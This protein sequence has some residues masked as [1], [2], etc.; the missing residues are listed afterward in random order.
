MAVEAC[1]HNIKL[2][3][4]VA[5]LKVQAE[6]GDARIYMLNHEKEFDVVSF[7]IH[8]GSVKCSEGPSF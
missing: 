5:L 1:E 8:L 7:E 4:G 2:N 6:L 3:G